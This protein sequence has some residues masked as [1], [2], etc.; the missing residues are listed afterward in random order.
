MKTLVEKGFNKFLPCSLG[1]KHGSHIR[2]PVRG[3]EEY[4]V[5]CK[6]QLKVDSFLDIR[7]DIFEYTTQY[8]RDLGVI[9]TIEPVWLNGEE[10]YHDIKLVSY[11]EDGFFTSDG[12]VTIIVLEKRR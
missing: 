9:T 7:A 12:Q 3:N 8:A 10:V 5:G 1:I 6:V 4:F 2:V 11:R